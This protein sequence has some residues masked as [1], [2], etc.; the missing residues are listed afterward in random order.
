MNGHNL[1]LVEGLLMLMRLYQSFVH[2]ELGIKYLRR[3]A[4]NEAIKSMRTA[5][6]I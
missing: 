4:Q 5:T 6:G 3:F 1:Y 2:F